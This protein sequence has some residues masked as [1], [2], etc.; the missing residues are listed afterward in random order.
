MEYLKV[1]WQHQFDDEP[2][3]LYSE[4]NTRRFENRKIEI[5]PDGSFG[6][7]TSD[8][9]FGGT[10]L[11]AEVMPLL[12]E[13]CEEKTFVPEVITREE[14]EKIWDRYVNFLS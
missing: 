10:E 9:H 2:L 7:A 12:E 14:F 11:S 5:Y 6:L 1:S 8:F 13:I 4:I 3:I